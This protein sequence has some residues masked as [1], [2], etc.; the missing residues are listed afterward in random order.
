MVSRNTHRHGTSACSM[1][2]KFLRRNGLLQA[3]V[4]RK[5]QI[6][7]VHVLGEW[8]TMHKHIYEPRPWLHQPLS[9]S[10]SSLHLISILSKLHDLSLSEIER[11][12]T[13]DA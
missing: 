6:A 11:V 4:E 9:E 7:L 10:C 5:C 2:D 8:K 3:P 12:E 1:P 13:G